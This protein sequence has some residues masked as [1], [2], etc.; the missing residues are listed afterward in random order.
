MSGFKGIV[1]RMGAFE[2]ILVVGAVFLV[3]L[4]VLYWVTVRG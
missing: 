2:W 4:A 3:F 1:A